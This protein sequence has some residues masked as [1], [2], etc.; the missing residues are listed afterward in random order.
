M[1]SELEQRLMFITGSYGRH[2]RQWVKY[3]CTLPVIIFIHVISTPM[4]IKVLLLFHASLILVPGV[5]SLLSRLKM[6][7]L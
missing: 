6:L 2:R 3:S 1:T 5:F 4:E 7:Q